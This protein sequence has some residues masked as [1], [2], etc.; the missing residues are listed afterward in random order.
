MITDGDPV[1]IPRTS[2]VRGI[3][4][5]IPDDLLRAAEGGLAVEDPFFAVKLFAESFEYL[6]LLQVSDSARKCRLP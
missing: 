1:S 2:E 6:R 3:S 4:A 5:E